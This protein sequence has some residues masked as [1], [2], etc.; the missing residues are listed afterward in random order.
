MKTEYYNPEEEITDAPRLIGGNVIK[1][2]AGQNFLGASVNGKPPVS[3]TGTAGSIPAAPAFFLFEAVEI[4]GRAPTALDIPR[5]PR[6]QPLQE[7]RVADLSEQKRAKAPIPAT[8]AGYPPKVGGRRKCRC[9]RVYRPTEAG[10]PPQVG[11]RREC[12]DTH[13]SR[14]APR[15][16]NRLLKAERLS[17]V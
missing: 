6:W 16:S 8:E 3:K 12:W 10:Y 13:V 17:R 4:E 15:P 14:P 11:G 9:T 1:N 2:F 7:H 5:L